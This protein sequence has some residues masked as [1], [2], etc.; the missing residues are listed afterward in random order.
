MEY[1]KPKHKIEN[2]A[3]DAIRK[4]LSDIEAIPADQLSPRQAAHY[5]YLKE[6]LRGFE[7]KFVEGY[8]KRTRGLPKYQ[9]DITFYAKLQQR[10]AH[11]TVIIGTREDFG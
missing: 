10:S 11:S 1:T 8:R 2:S 9:P 5:T 7:E 6:K 3:R 4:G